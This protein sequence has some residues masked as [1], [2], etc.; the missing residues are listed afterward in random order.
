VLEASIFYCI[1]WMNAIVTKIVVLPLASLSWI[2]N[3]G[4]FRAVGWSIPP[5]RE[6][7]PLI[8]IPE[9]ERPGALVRGFSTEHRIQE[10]VQQ[11]PSPSGGH[12]IPSALPP[13]R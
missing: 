9:P 2:E 13:Q 12:R 3:G 6:P 1:S 11:L 4:E 8:A 7:M 5:E 10:E